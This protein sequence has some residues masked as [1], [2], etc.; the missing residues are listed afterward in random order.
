MK[1]SRFVLGVILVIFSELTNW[2]NGSLAELDEGIVEVIQSQLKELVGV[3]G[4]IVAGIDG[5]CNLRE[6]S[7]ETTLN[8][9]NNHTYKFHTESVSYEDA[10]KTC[11]NEK[12]RLASSEI[13]KKSIQNELRN[14]L[15]HCQTSHST[16]RTLK[17]WVGLRKV[18]GRWKW[19]DG[20]NGE[21]STM[22]GCGE[23]NGK[24][25]KCVSMPA[26][27]FTLHDASCKS[28]R[29]FLCEIPHK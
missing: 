9:S 22:W 1:K 16:N 7:H 19:S 28:E 11:I 18:D 17:I 25:Q 21:N 24:K 20:A 27:R 23:P 26:Q 5:E 2:K 12:G 8:A 10:N 13:E 3:G 6:S 29:R 4:F 15:R 14:L